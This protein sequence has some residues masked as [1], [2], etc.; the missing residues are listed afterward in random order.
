[1]IF[2]TVLAFDHV[3]HRILIISNARL[4]GNDDLE[5]LYQFA[6]ARIGFVERE[7]ERTLSKAPQPRA[8]A[9]RASARTSPARRSSRWCAPPRSTSPPATSTRWCCRSASRR[10][11]SADPFT[12]YRALRH[13]NPSPYMYFLKVGGRVDRRLVA[14]DAGAG[15]GDARRDPPDRRHPAARQ[16]RGGR[17]PAGRGAEAQ[18]EGAR[19]A[20]H[21]GRP[22]AQRR[23]PRRRLRQRARRRPT[24]R[25][26]AT[27]T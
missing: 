6:C 19:R 4:T 2:D 17:R 23:R 16:D 22:R 7:L 25:S 14:R 11:V 10:Q 27:R 26:S 3:R 5:S 13:V 1:M 24:W 15:R 12:V 20:R 8:S 21:A 18:R 9:A